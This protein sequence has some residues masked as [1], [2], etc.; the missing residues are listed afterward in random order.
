MATKKRRCIDCR[1][2]SSDTECSLIIS[3]SE[4]EVFKIALR[5]AIEDHGHQDSPELKKYIR[6]MIKEEKNK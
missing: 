4:K 3:G 2:I 6:S 1:D 5:H